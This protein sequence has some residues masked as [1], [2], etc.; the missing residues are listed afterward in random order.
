MTGPDYDEIRDDQ[1]ECSKESPG[2]ILAP[3]EKSMEERHDY[4]TLMP[5]GEQE[6]T[7]S[8]ELKVVD[9]SQLYM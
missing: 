1:D 2:K 5:G 9:S 8:S 3:E 4:H 6:S 7:R